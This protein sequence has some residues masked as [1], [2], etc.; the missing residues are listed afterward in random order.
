MLGLPEALAAK[1]RRHQKH[2]KQLKEME[3]QIF[4]SRER[5]DILREPWVENEFHP[6]PLARDAQLPDH[7]DQDFDTI[8][9]N[10]KM[11]F[12]GF[13]YPRFERDY[14]GN[15]L[16]NPQRLPRGRLM[17]ERDAEFFRS[18]HLCGE[19]LQKEMDEAKLREAE[20]FRSKVCVDSLDFKVDGFNVEASRTNR[21]SRFNHE[22]PL[23]LD[24]TKDI[25]HLPVKSKALRIVRNAKLPSG[26]KVPLRAL[27][28]SSFSKHETYEDPHDF[29]L[30]LREQDPTTFLARTDKAHFKGE[31]QP[32][33]FATCIHR[34]TM[35]AKSD[36]ILARRSIVP[37]ASHEK[38]DSRFHTQM[39]RSK[40]GGALG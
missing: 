37:L 3:F 16:G 9:S 17:L 30:D 40:S 31:G 22:A 29:T 2:Q 35:K 21:N 14:D 12:G 26:K 11:I 23:Q 27:E 25:L 24:R 28:L 13:M 7:Q 34:D 20:L 39:H 4:H 36:K 8:P 19:G 38:I 18:V 32:L 15:N 10:G 33:D 1:E 6:A 5:I